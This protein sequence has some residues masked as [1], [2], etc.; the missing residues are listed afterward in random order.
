MTTEPVHLY[1][2]LLDVL[3]YRHYLEE[4][5][6][7]GTLRFQK[8]LSAAL[9]VFDNVNSAVFNV[10]AISD[11][12]IITCVDHQNFPE[13]LKILRNVFTA[14]L[15][16]DLLIRGGVSYSRHFES[17][18]LTYSHAVTRAYELE[19][20]SAVYPRIVIDSN[21]LDMYEVGS[22]LPRIKG[23]GLLC[24]ENG[25]YFLNTL[26]K[27]NWKTTYE[28]A[29]RIYT[30]STSA[31]RENEGALVKHQRLESYILNSPHAPTKT[32][33]YISKIEEI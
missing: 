29:K 30:N 26:T 18:R 28:A 15:E 16:Q 24:K 2:T 23:I 27:D 33:P 31:L 5:R 3:G 22:E 11:T 10:R 9:K 14:F 4:D 17:G 20:K 21:I 13:L 19:S 6:K 7:S 25:T 1:A 12:L 32:I 8:K